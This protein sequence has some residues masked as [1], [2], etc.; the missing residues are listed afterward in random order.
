MTLKIMLGAVP[1]GCHNIGDEAILECSVK[2][3]REVC[4]DCR[5]TVSTA[6]EK[7]TASKL[8]VDTCE[9]FGF[10]SSCDR[11][12]LSGVLREQDVFIWCGATGL[13]A[14]PE[15]ALD[16]LQAAQEAGKKT[17]LWAVGMSSRLN[18]TKYEV[19]PGKRRRLLSLVTKCSLNLLDAIAIE[20]RRRVRR[21]RRKIAKHLDAADLIIVRD[22]E[23]RDEVLKCGVTREIV[24]GADPAVLLE[25]APID[26]VR[27]PEAVRGAL[28]ADVKK[29][30]VCVSTSAPK[31]KDV[32]GFIRYLDYVTADGS[33]IAVLLPMDPVVDVSL[34]TDMRARM[35]HPERA[36]IVEG[37]SEPSEVLAILS[38]LDV[39]VSS[40]LH[41]LIFA[42][43]VGV[44]MVGISPGSKMDNFMRPFGLQPIGTS[45]DWDFDRLCQETK[46]LLE[47]K[48]AFSE[49]SREV[50]KDLLARLAVAKVRL[51]ALLTS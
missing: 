5:I 37:T 9:L 6:D 20:E 39:A 50:R 15:E 4:P 38:K 11:S 47:N 21:T 2:I 26:Q 18:P 28:T 45:E 23:S 44:P 43:I 12:R 31:F 46:R 16:V 36:V 8:G 22:P 25:P 7:N 27:L 41:M 3:I 1:F 14:Y 40:R 13:S 17:I 48:A 34:M 33:A 42:S 49:R 51:G 29:I 10:T 32:P 35:A 30:G 24:V 19:L